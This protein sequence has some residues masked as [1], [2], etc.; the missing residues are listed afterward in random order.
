[1][2][3]LN[4]DLML[5]VAFLLLSTLFSLGWCDD[6]DSK[7]I[8]VG[9]SY[10]VNPK[11]NYRDYYSEDVHSALTDG[12]RVGGKMWL[13]SRALTW[14]RVGRVTISLDLGEVSSVGRIKVHSSAGSV[15]GVSFP[16]HIFAYGSQDGRRFAYLGDLMERASSDPVSSYEEKDFL[17]SLNGVALRFVRL[18]VLVVPP[19]FSVD[20]VEVYAG[21]GKGNGMEFPI[22]P[23]AIVAD[24][25]RRAAQRAEESYAIRDVGILTKLGARQGEDRKTRRAELLRRAYPGRTFV[26]QV[27]SPWA[28][29]SPL[30][31][32]KDVAM[33]AKAQMLLPIDACDYKSVVVSNTS[34]GAIDLTLDSTVTGAKYV[35]VGVFEAKVARDR[36][37]VGHYD[38]LVLIEKSISL[39][40]GE[41]K[42][43]FLRFCGRRAGSASYRFA[44]KN[45]REQFQLAASLKAVDLSWKKYALGATTWSYLNGKIINDVVKAAV[46]DLIDHHEDTIVVPITSIG[47]YPSANVEKLTRYLDYYNPMIRAGLIKRVI[48]FVN[49]KGTAIA[50]SE[51]KKAE[52]AQWYKSAIGAV[53][54]AG[55]NK[56]GVYIY[57]FDEPSGGDLKAAS[58][59]FSW[60]RRALDGVKIFVTIDNEKALA[61][62]GRVDIAVVLP[63]IEGVANQQS[64]E[65]WLYD[66]KGPAKGNDVYTYYRMLPWRAV[67]KSMS[68]VGFWSYSDFGAVGDVWNDRSD[69][70]YN[71][72][73]IYID[74]AERL[75]SSRRWEAW[76]SGLEDAAFLRALD[77]KRAKHVSNEIA[78]SVIGVPLGSKG[79][80][81]LTKQLIIR[82]LVERP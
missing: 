72:S 18:E 20:E 34:S 76:R 73:P 47:A 67:A 9:K 42:F 68:G 48:L 8:S 81:D 54:S 53:E 33:E 62:L 51:P 6:I 21:K 78:K 19:Y 71:Y 36:D 35:D 70:G 37:G 14:K 59:V 27:V 22:L 69:G 29:I 56:E 46:Q 10:D 13:S 43:L 11:P 64:E 55:F 44:I 7:I 79:D 57:P 32:P 39:D 31:M 15:G 30:E 12:S 74:K 2:R 16:A 17:T 23:D 52:F 63:V 4:F 65:V 50:A 61:A 60:M 66:T 24:S 1:M 77:Q 49:Q 58:A 82:E 25:D 80:A 5:L 28:E 45:G 40:I 3:R 38:P 26:S 75:L 41:S